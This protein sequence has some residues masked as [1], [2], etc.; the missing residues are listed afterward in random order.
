MRFGSEELQGVLTGSFDTYWYADLYYNGERRLADIPISD[1]RFSEDADATV[2]QSGA[3]TVRWTDEFASSVLPTAV[4]DPL[5][6]FGATLHV[7]CFVVA[8]EFSERV[9]YGRF[10]IVDVPSARDEEMQF[11]GQWITTGSTVQLE[12]REPLAGIQQ[13]S[14]DIPTAPSD[15]SST[16]AEVGRITGAPLVRSVD[17]A[18]VPR[19][20]MY[21]E[22]KLDAVYE[23][24]SVV[25]DAVPH[26]T[27]DGAL[28]ARPNV[29]PDPVAD[30]T[31]DVIESVGSAMSAAQVYNRVVVR[32]TGGD[33]TAVLAVAEVTSG[34]LR[35]R[36]PDGS[37]SPFRART[38][39][40]ASEFVTTTDQA[41]AWAESEL[42]KVSTVRSRVA[43][44]VET[45]NPLRERGD[46][47]RVE[48]NRVWLVGRVN[49]I[50]RSG[51][52]QRL[53][54]E[55]ASTIPRETPAEVF[56]GFTG[57]GLFPDD[58]LFPAEDEYP[59]A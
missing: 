3:C 32:A 38:R 27:S 34:P 4:T 15:L 23:L 37:P 48:R 39:Y 16:W 53:T 58:E 17:D 28:S 33:Q 24:M 47:V 59:E 12:L 40:L 13:E 51:R 21:P 54:V 8:G 1:V 14:F 5:A 31:L 55:V 30:V 22:S 10:L 26:V 44:V 18:P 11:R 25:L 45:F 57:F 19:S 20:I 7:S 2:Q 6:P 42:A 35:V 52:T 50:D 9:R 29:W 36:N 46:V 43:E 49:T 56:P 41:Q